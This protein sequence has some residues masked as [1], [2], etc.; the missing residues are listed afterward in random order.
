MLRFD[1]ELRGFGQMAGYFSCGSL[2]QASADARSK[3]SAA[4]GARSTTTPFD[5]D[6]G[7]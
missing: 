1:G 2:V 7:L 5:E 6:G 3:A 4:C